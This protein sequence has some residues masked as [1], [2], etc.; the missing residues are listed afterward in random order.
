VCVGHV[1]S[2]VTTDLQ[3]AK[4]YFDRI[5][6]NS[7][8]ALQLFTDDAVIYEPFSV[9]DGLRGKEAIE[10]F[11]KVASIANQGLQKKISFT[12]HSKNSIEVLVQFTRGG[13]IKGKFQFRTEDVQTQTGFEKK[14]KELRIQFTQ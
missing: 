13:T 9:E 14:I 2:P 8:A 12:A 6:V 1:N 4:E 3:L 10:H 7:D 5:P 11:L